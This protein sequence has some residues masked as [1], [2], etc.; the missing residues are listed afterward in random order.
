MMTPVVNN[1]ASQNLYQSK[2]SPFNKDLCS[3]FTL[4]DNL[5][6]AQQLLMYNVSLSALYTLAYGVL[7]KKIIQHTLLRV[8]YT[9][10]LQTLYCYQLRVPYRLRQQQGV[11]M[12]QDLTKHFPQYQV[13]LENIWLP[14]ADLST[15]TIESEVLIIAHAQA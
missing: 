1:N 8:A 4:D 12:Q 15:Q 13:R 11:F 2:L 10:P 5:P 14:M 3:G 6:D 9:A 7:Q